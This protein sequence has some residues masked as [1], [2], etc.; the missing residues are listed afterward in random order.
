MKTSSG[1]TRIALISAG[2]R[3]A[4]F[5]STTPPAVPSFSG[6]TM[7]RDV[8]DSPVALEELVDD[9]AR[10]R[11]DDRRVVGDQ[12]ADPRP[13]EVFDEAREDALRFF[14]GAR[15]RR[16]VVRA[17]RRTDRRACASPSASLTFER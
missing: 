7:P 9:G 11:N 17:L 8:D 10:V 1:T 16:V 6:G 14:S 15:Q 5:D 12:V 13:P 4:P 3:N 2:P